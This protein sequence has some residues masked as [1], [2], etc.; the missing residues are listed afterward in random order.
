[1]IYAVYA[2]LLVASGKLA[3]STTPPAQEYDYV[4]V[5]SGP[6]GGPLA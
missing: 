4:I 5:G 2:L 3:V 6:G 1:M